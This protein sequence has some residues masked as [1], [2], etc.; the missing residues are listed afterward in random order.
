M[1]FLM[2]ILILQGLVASE[3]PLPLPVVVV[4]DAQDVRWMVGFE[5]D[6]TRG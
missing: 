5:V 2:S 6:G 1:S 4:D 3:R